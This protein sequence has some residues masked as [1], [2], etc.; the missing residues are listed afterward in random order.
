[1]STL[2]AICFQSQHAL[3][4][5]RAA[6]HRPSLGNPRAEPRRKFKPRSRQCHSFLTPFVLHLLF[7]APFVL[8]IVVETSSDPKTVQKSS[9][10]YRLQDFGTDATSELPENN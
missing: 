4:P 10:I 7:S 6:S 9:S 8:R 2:R 5:Q 3:A 1:V